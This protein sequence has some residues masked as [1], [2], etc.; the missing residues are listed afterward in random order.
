MINYFK[1]KTLDNEEIT[2]AILPILRTYSFVL[3]CS[4]R[5]SECTFIQK[6]QPFIVLTHKDKDSKRILSKPALLAIISTFN[7]WGAIF[8]SA[9]DIESR[10]LYQT[11]FNEMKV[12]TDFIDSIKLGLNRALHSSSNIVAK[13]LSPIANELA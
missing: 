5:W 9:V 13:Y 2:E 11:L 3:S 8:I 4:R 10:N 7:F 6:L 1:K 12:T